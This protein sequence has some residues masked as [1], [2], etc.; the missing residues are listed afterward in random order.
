MIQ[1]THTNTKRNTHSQVHAWLFLVYIWF[2]C[3]LHLIIILKVLSTFQRS[4]IGLH[5]HTHFHTAH[6]MGLEHQEKKKLPMV[7]FL[8]FVQKNVYRIRF[9]EIRICPLKGFEKF[10]FWFFAH[11]KISPSK[12]PKYP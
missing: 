10:A 1:N 7:N 8:I 3:R 12:G 6:H 5:H 2:T 9:Q 11:Y 4:L